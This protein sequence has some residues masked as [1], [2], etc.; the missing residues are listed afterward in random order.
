MPVTHKEAGMPSGWGVEGATAPADDAD[1]NTVSPS[2]F[3]AAHDGV[4]ARRLVA[5]AV[6]GAIAMADVSATDLSV[7]IKANRRYYWRFTGLYVTAATA[8]AIRLSINGPTTPT[9]VNHWANVVVTIATLIPTWNAGAANAIA[10]DAPVIAST[11]GP[12]AVVCP[13]LYEGIIENGANAGTLRPRF[14]SEIA[15][16]SVTI[17]R[18]AVLQVIELDN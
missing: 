14:A 5:D 17:Q 10:Y 4:W 7:S 3:I 1:A 6:S 13:F 9:R 8:T 18:G 2:Q 11:A 12:G 15:S 16:S